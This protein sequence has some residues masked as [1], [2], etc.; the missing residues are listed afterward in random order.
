V[1]ERII[2]Q[3]AKLFNQF[4]VKAVRLEDIAQ[5]LGISKKTLYQHF[6]DKEELVQL[7]LESQLNEAL[8]EANAIHTHASNAVVEALLIWD[9][10]IRYQRTTNPNLL[11]D[12]ERHYPT[13][14]N[15][16]QAFRTEYINTILAANLRRGMEQALYRADLNE[17]VI[18]W[19]WIEQSQWD[20]PYKDNAAETAIKHHFVRGLLTQKGLTLYETLLA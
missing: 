13:P 5:E 9:R 20:I 19:L 7:M 4:G 11:R 8:H 18:A 2:V 15:L 14:W 6:R 17:M 1:K 10:L 16:F 12:I 3:A